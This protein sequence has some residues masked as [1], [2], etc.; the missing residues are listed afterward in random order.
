MG[1]KVHPIGF[2]LGIG[3]NHQSQWFANPEIYPQLVAEDSFIR[4]KLLKKFSNSIISNIEI[5][6]KFD[7]YIQIIIYSSKPGIIL[8]LYKNNLKVLSDFLAEQVLKYRK[9]ISLTFD[10]QNQTIKSLFTSNLKIVIQIFEQSN[11]DTNSY[12]I[13]DFIVEQ[14]QK[15]VIFRRVLKK[16]LRRAQKARVQ[17][18]K[19][20]ISGRLNGAEIARREWIR[21][22]RVPLQTLRAGIDYCSKKA[23]TIYGILGVKVWVFKN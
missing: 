13:A 12:F 15:R 7:N 9:I 11:P 22:G 16:A 17:G 21:E 18:I 23:K 8:S 6:R 1:Q 2:R 20:Q 10:N 4:K 5:H 19:I 3:K 14:L